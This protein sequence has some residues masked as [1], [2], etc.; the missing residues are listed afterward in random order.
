MRRIIVFSILITAFII[1]GCKKD[2][3]EVVATVDDETLTLTELQSFYSPSQWKNTSNEDKRETVKDWIELT[4]LAKYSDE[5]G[6]SDEPAIRNRINTAIK[7]AKSN[8]VLA[9]EISLIQISEDELYSYYKIHQGDYKSSSTEY[10]IQ[11]IIVPNED[12]L[13]IVLDQLKNGMNFTEAVKEFSTEAIGA[14]GGYAGWVA[15]KNEDR[16]IYDAVSSLNSYEYTHLKYKND[17]CIVRYYQTRDVEEN[18]RFESIKNELRD[19]LYEEKKQ[20]IYETL[21]QEL[22]NKY[23]ISLS[24]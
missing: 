3:S 18:V 1:S 8:A 24:F 5:L 4:S 10:K 9:R 12:S 20:D 22:R 19:K 16:T 15:R 21:I 13:K 7:K 6:L 17:Y 2:N 23:E 14:S 11:R